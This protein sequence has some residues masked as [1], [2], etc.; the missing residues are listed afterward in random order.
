MDRLRNECPWD[1]EQTMES[2]RNNTIEECFELTDAILTGDMNEI[3]KE[4][5]DMLLHI[6]FYSKIASETGDFDIADVAD[7]ISEKLIYRHPHVF[8]D[9]E[10]SDAAQVSRNWEALKLKEKDG[11]KSVLSG[12]ATG[13]PALPKAY[14]IG[15]KVANVGFDWQKREDVWAKVK[16]EIAE[17]EVEIVAGNHDNLE[18]EFGDLFFSLTNAARLWGINPDTALER[19]NRKFIK[20]FNYLE[21]K[22][23]AQ[24]RKLTD[25]TLE[26]MDVYW[27]EAK[28]IQDSDKEIKTP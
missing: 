4:L 9:T 7:A 12:V 10:V 24:G 17:V 21:S 16:E 23:I 27:E 13:M 5:G 26:E 3:K 8:S 18:A 6:V 20:R 2:L 1:R 11:N 28:K 25:M 15:Q 19:T 14:R 22:T